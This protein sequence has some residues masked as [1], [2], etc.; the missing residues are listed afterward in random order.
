MLLTTGSL[1]VLMLKPWNYV[2]WLGICLAF[3][4]GGEYRQMVTDDSVD[5]HTYNQEKLLRL[6]ISKR[7]LYAVLGKLAFLKQAALWIQMKKIQKH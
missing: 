7:L 6:D 1:L 4:D 5:I 3:W 2:V